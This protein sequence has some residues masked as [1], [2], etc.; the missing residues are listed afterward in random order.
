MST[1]INKSSR[2]F[3]VVAMTPSSSAN[4]SASNFDPSDH[5]FES[6][7]ADRELSAYTKERILHLLQLYNG[8]Q[9]RNMH[10]APFTTRELDVV[11]QKPQTGKT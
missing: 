8:A 9:R 7:K 2:V 4:G 1:T 5:F 3:L 11:L 6:N 10:C